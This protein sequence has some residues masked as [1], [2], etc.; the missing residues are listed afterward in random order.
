[1]Y[2]QVANLDPADPAWGD[3]DRIFWSVGHKAPSLYLGLGM[4]GFF[5]VEDTVTLRKFDSPFQ[6]HPHWLKLPG[7]EISSGSLGQ[8]LSVGFGS[9]LAAKLDKKDHYTYVFMGDGELQE[10]QIW[11]AAMAAGHYQLD[12]L[13]GIVD[14]NDLQIDGRV[15]DV[16][17]IEPLVDK[18]ESFGWRVIELDGHDM[19]AIVDGFEEAKQLT[20]KPTVIIAKTI[21]GKGVD[22]IEDK[23]GWHGRSP[24]REELDQALPQLGLAEL[25]DVEAL[26]KKAAEFQVEVESKIALQVPSYPRDYF[27]NKQQTMQVDMKPTRMGF[28]GALKEYGGDERV[29]CLGMDISGSI[30]IDQFCKDNPERNER[31]CSVG[32]A[33]QNGTAAAAGLARAGK[34]PVIGTY[35]VFASG[36]AL[37]QIRTTLAYSE[38]DVLIAGAH[39]G[40][41]VGPDG[42]THQALE[43]IATIA[44]IP[45]MTLV[46]PVDS[47]ETGRAT[48]DLLFDIKGTKY[49]RFAREA[50]PIV[51]THDTP[52][53]IGKANV[54]RYRGEQP[55]FMDAFETTLAETYTSENE[56]LCIISCGPEVTEAMR[57]AWMLK[58]EYG[59]ETRILNMH[60]VKPLDR[61]AI[62]RAGLEIGTILTAEEHQVGGFG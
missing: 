60:T 6:G 20:G 8:G 42:A 34:L 22:F 55:R 53:V 58:E 5:P 62:I 54:I 37:D 35:G 51:T 3:R 27:W 36:R 46:V 49:L 24:T 14:K 16:L 25:P 7:V 15:C 44:A 18:W 9:A 31:F 41:S 4:A 50:T 47:V 39:G 26:L 29:V 59:I 32:I 38:V 13:I 21:K 48:H 12:H 52:F 11:E 28:G 19:Q 57:A 45:N 33:E 40:I 56:Q 43:E 30:T 10:G 23:A 61:E 2:L 1:L 17:N